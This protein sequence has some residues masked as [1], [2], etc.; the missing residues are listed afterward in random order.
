MVVALKVDQRLSGG[1]DV[2]AIFGV[3]GRGPLARLAQHVDQVGLL[4]MIPPHAGQRACIPA[5]SVPDQQRQ[6]DALL[7]LMVDALREVGEGRG[8]QP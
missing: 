1:G 5:D 3:P 8:E 7:L 2:A 6:E 4:P